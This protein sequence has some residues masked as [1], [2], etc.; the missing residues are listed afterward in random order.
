MLAPVRV[1]LQ[2]RTTSS[3]LPA[4]SLLPVGGIPLA[5]LCAKRLARTGLQTVL[6]TSDLPSDDALAESAARHGVVVFRGSHDDV[7]SRFIVCCADL[8]DEALIVRM[9][10]DNPVPDAAFVEGLVSLAATRA[11][12]YVGTR[13]PADGLPY[14]LSG[15]VLT[16]RALRETAARGPSQEE[17]EHV[18]PGVLARAGESAHLPPAFFTKRDRSALR[19]TVDTLADYLAVERLFASVVDPVAAPWSTIVERMESGSTSRQEQ[20]LR[21]PLARLTLGTAQFGMN[22]GSTNRTGRLSD[23]ELSQVLETAFAA[24]V[25]RFDTARA[26]GDAEVRLGRHLAGI[27]PAGV[28]ICTKISPLDAVGDHRAA[29]AAAVDAS[30]FHSCHALRRSRLDVVMFHR[31]ADMFRSDGSA[32]D[33]LERL[34][35]DGVVDRIGISVYDPDEAVRCLRDSRVTEL[36]IPFNILDTR[37]LDESFQSALR[38]R[39]DVRVHVRSVFLQG[40]LLNPASVWPAWFTKRTDM[41]QRIR[42]IAQEFDRR[43]VSDLCLSYVLSHDWVTSAIVGIDG[44]AHLRELLDASREPLMSADERAMIATTFAGLPERLL[45][46]S[47]WNEHTP[48]A[49]G[50]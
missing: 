3:R 10:A 39:P 30:V 42:R 21:A 8:P 46:P 31:S 26:Y 48:A 25:T 13:W 27:D 2:A 28:H 36:Q 6:A 20:V 9:T 29:I 4:K 11:T 1:V 32:I 7:L 37:W 34:A 18:I 19:C 38:A 43:S 16:L 17:R 44:V 49:V 35:A 41:E 15:E 23:E 12:P 24:G 47:K 50:R 33:Q 40:L 14:G 22:Y 45:N 5:V